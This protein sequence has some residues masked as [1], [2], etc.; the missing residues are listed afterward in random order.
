MKKERNSSFELLRIIAIIMIILD[1]YS[2]HGGWDSFTCSNFSLNVF[3]L[4][5]MVFGGNLGCYIFMII[6]GYFMIHGK[7]NYKKILKLMLE[8]A[9]YSIAIF[10][11]FK[12]IKNRNFS[13]TEIVQ[14]FLFLIYG[15]WFLVNYIILSFFIPFLNKFF[16]RLEKEEFK[17]LLITTIIV[18][19]IVPSICYYLGVGTWKFSYFDFMLVS[20]MLGS[21]IGL[22]GINRFEKKKYCIKTILVV[23]AIILLL[24]ISFDALAIKLNK[25]KFLAW[26]TVANYQ[27]SILLILFAISIFYIFKNI[28]LKSNIIN[29]IASSTLGIYLIHDNYLIRHWIWREFFPNNQ[30]LYSN[31]LILHCIAK[32]IGIFVVCIIIDKLRIYLIEKPLSKYGEK[33]YEFLEKTIKKVCIKAEKYIN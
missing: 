15:N 2:F 10:L 19:S 6:T 24:I 9:F 8:M 26:A 18:Y 7:V 22:Y 25:D 28:T 21:Y 1:H 32:V 33:I 31:L 17:K 23:S 14:N 12:F 13:K 4:Q 3:L 11:I 20:Y 29:F 30:Y 27:T 16:L 5:I